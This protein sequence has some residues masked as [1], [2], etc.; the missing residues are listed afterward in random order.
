MSSARR[1]PFLFALL[2]FGS[3]G[4]LAEQA[5]G[6]PDD[7][8]QPIHFRADNVE[9]DLLVGGLSSSTAD[10]ASADSPVKRVVATGSVQIGQGSMR[11]TADRVVIESEG[12]RITLMDAQ[13]EPARYRQQTE[14]GAGFIEARASNIIYRPADARIELIGRAFL[15]RDSDEFRGEVITYDIRQ[16]KVV[17]TGETEG[18]EMI[19]QPGS[20]RGDSSHEISP[21]QESSPSQENS[22]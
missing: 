10:D 17:A 16:G 13:G 5:H 22:P 21:S 9:G 20:A 4:G 1:G 7:A 18:V 2:V 15:T 6:L 11:L 19:I 8:N 12:D 14:P 3:P